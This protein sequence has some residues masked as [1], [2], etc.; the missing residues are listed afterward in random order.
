MRGPPDVFEDAGDAADKVHA[1]SASA[2]CALAYA[3]GL[4][5]AGALPRD[6][7]DALECSESATAA[8]GRPLAPTLSVRVEPPSVDPDENEPAKE[9]PVHGARMPDAGIAGES[10]PSAVDALLPARGRVIVAYS[11]ASLPARACASFALCAS[12]R[13]TGVERASGTGVAVVLALAVVVR[14]VVGKDLHA[15]HPRRPAARAR[16]DRARDRDAIW[17]GDA[18]ARGGQDRRSRP[19]RSVRGG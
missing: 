7:L 5:V 2:L 15:R 14:A 17:G 11:D 18:A 13:R 8:R 3:A 9:S 10:T 4:A 12:A 16:G 1:R 19:R 6:A